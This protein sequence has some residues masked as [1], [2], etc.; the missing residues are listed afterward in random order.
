MTDDTEFAASFNFPIEAGKIREFARATLDDNTVYRSK[1]DAARSGFADI[2]APPTFAMASVFFQTPESQVPLDLD[3][4]Y[5]LHGEQEF[6]YLGP[7][8][9]G[10][11]LTGRSR[12]SDRYEKQG[13][14]GG[15]MVFTVLETQYRNQRDELVL[16]VRQTLIQPEGALKE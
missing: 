4:R 10:D 9:A 5:A 8:L 1:E 14:R 6:E 15:T 16:N 3:F 13:K 7:I 2:P 11:Q 12:I